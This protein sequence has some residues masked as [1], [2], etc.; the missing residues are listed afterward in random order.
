[1]R[2][3]QGAVQREYVA[4]VF[5]VSFTGDIE[6]SVAIGLE[7]GSTLSAQKLTEPLTFTAYTRAFTAAIPP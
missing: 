5:L 1:V 6:Q 7:E 2:V 3:G 4:D